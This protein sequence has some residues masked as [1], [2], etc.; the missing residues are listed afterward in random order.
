MAVVS[1]K[2]QPVRILG[3]WAGD[4]EYQ[5]KEGHRKWPTASHDLTHSRFDAGG[6]L[7]CGGCIGRRSRGGGARADHHMTGGGIHKYNQN[8]YHDGR[9]TIRQAGAGTS[10]SRESIQLCGSLE[11]LSKVHEVE[12]EEL[13]VA[14][15]AQRHT[16]VHVRE[17]AA[18]RYYLSKRCGSSDAERICTYDATPFV[19]G[20]AAGSLTMTPLP[21]GMMFIFSEWLIM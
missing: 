1:I 17:D 16:V 20:A 14:V 21:I 11:G 9:N 3:A 18:V 6:Q 19:V 4:Y 12:Q 8:L 10:Y 7:H 2:G 5:H 13:R 15:R